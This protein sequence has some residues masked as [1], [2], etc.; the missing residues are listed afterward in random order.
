M[1]A[2]SYHGMAQGFGNIYYCDDQSQVFA[3]RDNSEDIVW[4]NSDL[5]NRAITAPTAV[6][7]YIAVADYEGYVHLLSQIDGRIVGRIQADDDGVRANLLANN[8]RL[9]V[10]GNSGR[11]TAYQLQ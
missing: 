1:E 3:I 7:N 4:E 2:S 6:G 11:L 10:F 8:G 9:Y 5:L